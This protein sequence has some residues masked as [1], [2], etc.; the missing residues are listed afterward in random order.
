MRKGSMRKPAT[1]RT[2]R[3][4]R[5]N[6]AVGEYFGDAWSLAKRTATGLNEIRKL[7]NVEH[8]YFDTDVNGNSATQAGAV[9]SLS[10]IGQ[11]DD[12]SQRDG[13]SIKVQS[14]EMNGAVFRNVAAGATVN[15]TVRIVVVRDLQNAGAAP[16]AADIL[17]TVGTSR[18]PYAFT[19]YLNGSDTNKRFT[20][21]YDEVFTLD[22]AHQ[23]RSFRFR[24]D[25]DCHVYFRGT[26]TGAASQGNGSYYAVLLANTAATLPSV[27]M[28]TR[29]RFT[30]N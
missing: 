14:F 29:I 7:I 13:D 6:D 28:V 8:K 22:N 12:V 25:H 20:F 21:I 18:A 27:D 9:L 5:K 3:Q 23:V 10:L 16:T 26:T 1:R 24:T 19:D 2:Q 4:T 11:G 15:E 17:E 30:D